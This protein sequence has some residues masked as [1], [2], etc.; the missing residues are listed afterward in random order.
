[1][2]KILFAGS[3]CVPFVT[4]GGLG[5]VMGSLPKA[6]S[7]EDM[8][9]RVIIPN[10]RCIPEEYKNKMSYLAHFYMTVGHDGTPKYVGIL[11]FV[12]DGITYYFIDCNDYFSEGNPYT[13]MAKDIE[14]FVFFDKAVLA[15]LPVIGFEPDIIHCHD[16]QTG[17]I[18]VYLRTLFHDTEMAQKAKCIFTIHNLKFQGIANMDT[19]KYISGL[20]DYAFAGDKMAF[21]S[22]A[23]MLKG[24]LA[25]ADKITTVSSTYSGEIKTYEYGEGLEGAICQYHMKLCG[26]VNGIDYCLYNPSTDSYLYQNYSAN[27][28]VAGKR[29]NK[30]SLQKELGLE[31]GEGKFLI[32]LVSRLTDQKGLDLVNS[33]MGNILD[34]NTQF[35][36]LGTGEKRYED[37]FRYYENQYRGQACSNIMYSDERAH[38]LYAAADTMLVPS[39]FE[40]CGLT[41]LISF[42]YGTIPIVRETGGLKDTVV[43]YNEYEE[44]GNGF[45]FS[46]YHSHELL[47]TIN[48]A[49][50][51]FFTERKSWTAMCKRAMKEDF[52]WRKSA[53]QYK[54]LYDSLK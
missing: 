52:S 4:T 46:G 30:L 33:I 1:M 38:K 19:M 17:L 24:A 2:M 31:Q 23:N 3:E 5:D 39:R 25:Y 29:K 20:P 26:I 42:R 44:T 51:I 14:K 37:M 6:L 7:G 22:D 13:S 34:E 45:S 41:Q 53:G 36:V 21:H 9:V 10:Y 48:Y 50:H 11:S 27:N 49:K 35:V 43:P 8:D 54:K 40:P 15:A 12:L 16:W 28:V 32:G 47:N 18:P